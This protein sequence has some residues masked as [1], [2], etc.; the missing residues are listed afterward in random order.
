MKQFYIVI[1][2]DEKKS[3]ILKMLFDV[4]NIDKSLIFCKNRQ[5]INHLIEIF[6]FEN[7]IKTF[8]SDLNDF[9]NV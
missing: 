3:N 6:G 4:I 5:T 9:H 8:E 2:K 7:W 1:R